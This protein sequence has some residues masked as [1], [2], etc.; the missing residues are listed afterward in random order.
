MK[1]EIK[2]VSPHVNIPEYG[3]LG[4]AGLDLRACITSPLTLGPRDSKLIPSG[5]A[6]Y[7]KDPTL[8]GLIVPRSGLGARHGIVLGNLTGVIDSDYQGEVMISL[9]NRGEL[10]YMISPRERVAQM[11]FVPV[12][13]PELVEVSR[14]T[15]ATGR[16]EGGFGSTGAT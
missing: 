16:G 15:D 6:I 14:F 13:H 7:I 8:V 11:M 10:P 5:L 2:K 3:S 12:L 1:I 4:A 9:W